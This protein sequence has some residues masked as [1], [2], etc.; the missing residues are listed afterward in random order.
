MT[1]IIFTVVRVESKTENQ[2]QYHISVRRTTSNQLNNAKVC[3]LKVVRSYVRIVRG[4]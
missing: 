2:L 3:K 1:Q 4:L